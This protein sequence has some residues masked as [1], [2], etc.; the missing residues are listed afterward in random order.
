MDEILLKWETPYKFTKENLKGR[1]FIAILKGFPIQ[2]AL[3]VISFIIIAVTQKET[4]KEIMIPY[5]YMS[6]IAGALLFLLFLQYGGRNKTSMLTMRGVK[7]GPFHAGWDQLL[8]YEAFPEKG[9][10][11]LHYK[12]AYGM[13]TIT[14]KKTDYI[15]VEADQKTYP[16]AEKI[17]ER[18]LMKINSLND[19][20][21]H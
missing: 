17:I 7:T 10:L 6:M 15:T 20:L 8:A 9:L 12:D 14:R 3:A 11:L 21:M 1:V 5:V 16:E 13:T 19:L 18:Y 4:T 2:V